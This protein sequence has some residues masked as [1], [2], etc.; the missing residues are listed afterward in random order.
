MI[1]GVEHHFIYFFVICTY[2][3]FGFE[4]VSLC[5]P[6][7]PELMILLCQSLKVGITGV[8]HHTWIVSLWRNVYSSP[9]HI[10]ELDCSNFLLLNCGGSIYILD[11]NSLSNI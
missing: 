11:I 6:V 8:C 1:S 9:L 7:Q 3:L 10:F 5:S 4:I 2:S